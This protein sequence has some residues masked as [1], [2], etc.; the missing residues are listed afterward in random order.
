MGD[1]VPEEFLD[2]ILGTVM[3][4][5]V[6]LTTSGHVVDRDIITRHLLTDQKDPFNRQ[7]LTIE[8]LQ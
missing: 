5:P 1:D 3:K 4:D 7:D 2:P 6:L 8:M